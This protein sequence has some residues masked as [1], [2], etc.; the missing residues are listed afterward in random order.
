MPCLFLFTANKING[1]AT[2]LPSKNDSGLIKKLNMQATEIRIKEELTLP[3]NI[4]IDKKIS[5]EKLKITDAAVQVGLGIN[6]SRCK[7]D[8]AMYTTV[9]KRL[10]DLNANNPNKYQ[11]KMVNPSK[12]IENQFTLGI[13]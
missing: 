4:C 9:I 5:V 3:S 12:I 1:I 10:L 11:L 6:Q 2:A 13:H 7:K 8:I